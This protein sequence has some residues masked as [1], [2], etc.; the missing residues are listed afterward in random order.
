MQNIAAAPEETETHKGSKT[1]SVPSTVLQRMLREYKP[2]SKGV[3]F[4]GNEGYFEVRVDRYSIHSSDH[5]FG[6]PN[7][8]PILVSMD[9][10]IGTVAKILKMTQFSSVIHITCNGKPLRFTGTFRRCK[11]SFIQMDI[12]ARESE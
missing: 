12:F 8:D 7:N 5:V 4:S 9:L 3:I 6:E 11:S 1:I 2:L 10:C